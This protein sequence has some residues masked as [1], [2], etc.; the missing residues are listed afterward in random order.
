MTISSA[1]ADPAR[2]HPV[3]T[4]QDDAALDGR[5]IVG[6][7]RID[8]SSTFDLVDPYR[9]DLVAQITVA[10]PA[11][12]D[13]A[14]DLARQGTEELRAMP[15]HRRTAILRTAA[16]L[17]LDRKERLARTTARQT[18]KAI[19]DAR[20]EVD[21]ASYTLAAAAAAIEQLGEPLPVPDVTPGGEGLTAFTI[22]EPLGVIAAITPFNSPFNLVMHKVA[23]AI[24]TANAAIVKPASTAPL[25]ALQV[26]EVLLEAGLPGNALSVLPGGAE[27]VKGIVA[28]D[29]VDAVTLTGGHAAA[30]AIANAAPMKKL[31]FELG[32]S[33][34]NVVHADADLD[35]AASALAAGGFSNTGQSC[36]SV[37]RII[38]H[39]SIA[40]DLIAKVV[41]G[42]ERLVA[43]D[44]LDDA[45]DVGTLVTEREAIRVEEWIRS[46]VTAGATLHTGG[47]RRG[48]LIAP[49]VLSNVPLDQPL[50]CDEVFGPVVIVIPYD[51]IDEAFQIANDSSYG[52]QSAIFTSS[53]D[54]AFRATRAMTAGAVFVNRSTNFRLDHMPFGGVKDS[55]NT[56]EGGRFTIDELTTTK[57]V[58]IDSSLTGSPHPLARH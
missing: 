40:P 2:G 58:L 18:G 10:D 34:P 45:T 6:G 7:E 49:A 12:V 38:A 36:N 17:L 9:G 41:A 46:A 52:L 47:T 48:A 30:A 25:S 8:G 22:R 37:Q 3:A 35:W 33:G 29:R 51:T 28:D 4:G 23:P 13:R 54:I 31:L 53:L 11:T 15:I 16:R 50:A 32:G 1:P 43:G 21:R 19:R 44:P 42:A 39:R 57:L 27:V 24:A 20:R 5:P 56:R 26:A 55:G 14:L